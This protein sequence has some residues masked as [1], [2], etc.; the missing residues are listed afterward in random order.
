[1]KYVITIDT[2]E[3][4]WSNYSSTKNSTENIRRIDSLQEIFNRNNVKP[5]YLISYPVATNP[6]SIFILRKILEKNNCEI[7]MHCHPWNTPPFEEEINTCN[8]ML[9]NLPSSLVLKKLTT[10]YEV[11]E[12]NFRVSPVSFRA[13][14]LG[15]SS[16]V[17]NAL[18][19]LGFQVDSS[20]SPYT[21]WR[22]YGGP[23]FS[24]FPLYPYKFNPDNL[25]TPCSDGVLLELPVTIGFLQSNFTRCQKLSRFLEG[26]YGK[27]LRLKGILNKLRLLNKIWLSPETSSASDMIKLAQR[28]QRLNYSFLNLSFH[29]TSLMAGLGPFVRCKSDE[30][31]FLDKIEK[32]LQYTA[33]NN[34]QSTTLSHYDIRC[35]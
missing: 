17:A 25:K 34:M 20:V 35:P 29:S 27:K 3:D 16:S 26:Y 24:D 21:D 22:E 11:I 7:G 30:K 5:T 13:G 32:F 15:F 1:M 10:L 6:N 33:K 31:I 28:L 12:K 2:E 8:S 23:D 14:R 9:C 19:K 4:N 18:C